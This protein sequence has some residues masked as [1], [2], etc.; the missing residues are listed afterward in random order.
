STNGRKASTVNATL[1][2]RVQAKDRPTGVTANVLSISTSRTRD[3]TTLARLQFDV[4][5]DGANWHALE[6]HGVA[7]L[8]VD[9]V[10]GRYNLV[11][12]SKT[13]WSNDV[14]QF[15]VF[16]LDQSNPSGTVRIVLETFYGPDCVELNALEIDH[17]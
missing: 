15:A 3:L 9:C 4:V 1:F 8:H 12:S 17:A 11:T 7:R 2:T 6:R 10:H 5:H 13:L 16:V 14:S